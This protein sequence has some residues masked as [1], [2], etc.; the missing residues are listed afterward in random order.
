M[1]RAAVAADLPAV[2]AIWNPL[3]RDTLVTFT[4]DLKSLEDMQKMLSDKARDG[5]PFLVVEQEGN[6]LGFATYGSFRPGP[7]YRLTVEHSIILAPSARGRGI[8]RALLTRV[9]DH[10][11]TAGMHC[12]IGGVSGD[13]AEGRAFHR[14]MGYAEAAVLPEVGHKFGRWCDLV[15][16]QKFLT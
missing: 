6:V 13:N 14:A 16:M 8:G 12:Q 3:I 15:L 4:T 7:G 5:H 11:R 10:A 1:I 2:M 9:E